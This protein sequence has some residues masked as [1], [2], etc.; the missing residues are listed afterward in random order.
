M[1]DHDEIQRLRAWKERARAELEALREENG[2]LA[3]MFPDTKRVTSQWLSKEASD[4][5]FWVVRNPQGNRASWGATVP[6]TDEIRDPKGNI[7]ERFTRGR[8][9]LVDHGHD[10]KLIDEIRRLRAHIFSMSHSD[11]WTLKEEAG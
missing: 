4:G 6:D 5:R 3:A 11:G 10:G 8:W 1:T 7:I 2:A 9:D